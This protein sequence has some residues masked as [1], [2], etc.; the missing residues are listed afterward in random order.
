M[1]VLVVF[2]DFCRK[3]PGHFWRK[4]SKVKKW[5]CLVTYYVRT[6]RSDAN[7][8]F[9]R[10]WPGRRRQITQPGIFSLFRFLRRFLQ[11]PPSLLFGFFSGGRW[12][13]TGKKAQNYTRYPTFWP[14]FDPIRILRF[15]T[16][17]FWLFFDPP[18][19]KL[20]GSYV[21]TPVFDPQNDHPK[22]YTFHT[23]F[24]PPLSQI[25]FQL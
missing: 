1:A 6:T 15:L 24:C 3:K 8:G 4:V 16:L 7:S 21:T 20:I 2:G 12:P 22:K 19:L 9:L 11:T 23:R 5:V 10:G 17:D 25:F 13:M 14:I 18:F